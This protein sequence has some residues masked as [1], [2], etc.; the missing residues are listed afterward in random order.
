MGTFFVEKITE[1]VD[2]KVIAHRVRQCHNYWS[3]MEEKLHVL[4][5]LEEGRETLRFPLMD[6]FLF[7]IFSFQLGK[8]FVFALSKK[9]KGLASELSLMGVTHHL[10][11]LFAFQLILSFRL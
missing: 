9:I 2:D 6:I 11:I 4:H 5:G 8:N 1:I 3:V 7:R 10:Q